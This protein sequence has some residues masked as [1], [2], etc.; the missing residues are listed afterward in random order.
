MTKTKKMT[1]CAL[2]CALIA[3]GAFIQIPLPY[4]DYFTFQFLFVIMAGLILGSKLGMLSA[5]LYVAI[6][7]AGFPIFAAGGGIMY[8]IKPS[9]GYLIGFIVAAYLTGLVSEKL[10]EVNFKNSL[11]AA[12]SGLVAVYVIGIG[13]K[14]FMLNLVTGVKTSLLVLIM[15]AFPLDMPGDF[16]FCIIASMLNVRIGKIAGVNKGKLRTR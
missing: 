1:M 10:G 3:I 15:S 11:I 7:L 6:G 5:A 9:F 14:Y 2:F 16:V 4:L 8:V 12:L 13:Y